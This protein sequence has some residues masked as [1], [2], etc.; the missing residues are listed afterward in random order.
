MGTADKPETVQKTTKVRWIHL[1]YLSYHSELRLTFQRLIRES[2]V[3][4]GLWHPNIQP[5]LGYC[6]NLCNRFVLVSPLCSNNSVMTYIEKNP[7]AN[8]LQLVSIVILPCIQ[9]RILI[10]KITPCR[11]KGL[12]RGWNIS[13]PNKWFMQIFIL[14]ASSFA[15]S[16]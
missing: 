7:T 3:W 12:Q 16:L 2:R 15:R 11:W 13:T 8:R 1:S 6:F 9:F 10:T 4:E 5:Y 14:Y